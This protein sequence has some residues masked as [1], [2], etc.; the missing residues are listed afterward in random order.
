MKINS[1][2]IV[3]HFAWTEFWAHGNGFGIQEF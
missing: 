2:L 1:L 3:I